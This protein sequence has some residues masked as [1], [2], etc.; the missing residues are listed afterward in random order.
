MNGTAIYQAVAVIFT[1]QIFG[2]NLSIMDQIM[3]MFTAT[4]AAIGTAGIPGSG[5]IMLTIVLGAA[6]L[7]MEGVA[8][9]AGIDRIL[10]M[11]R[12][13]PNI[14]GDAAAAVVVARSEKTLRDTEDI[15]EQVS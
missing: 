4:L 5:L 12:V 2:I 8:L 7:P 3:V 14:V 10:N 15:L 9:L 6:N 11:G 13:V 1:A